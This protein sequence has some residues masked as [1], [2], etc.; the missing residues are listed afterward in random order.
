MQA[1]IE[2]RAAQVIGRVLGPVDAQAVHI[3]VPA[4]QLGQQGGTVG[5][6][7][8]AGQAG[9]AVYPLRVQQ[10]IRAPALVFIDRT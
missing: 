3:R 4:G 7:M 9:V 6:H 5:L 2:Q 1:E 8:G 10:T